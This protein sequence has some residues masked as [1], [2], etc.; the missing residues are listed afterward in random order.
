MAAKSKGTAENK[1]FRANVCGF[2]CFFSLSPAP[3]TTVYT[4]KST[5]A[6]Q[7]VCFCFQTSRGNAYSAENN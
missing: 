6:W 4:Q 2:F 3:K 1:V 7:Q 5:P